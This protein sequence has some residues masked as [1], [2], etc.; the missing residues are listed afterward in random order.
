MAI[1]D[2]IADMLTMIRN[3]VRVKK[4]EVIT[5][6]SGIKRDIAKILK[7][8]GY[9]K[10]F[11]V[12]KEDGL[13]KLKIQLKFLPVKRSA[14]TNIRRVSRPGLRKYAGK[15]KIPKVL[16]GLGTAI[17]STSK[18]LMSDKTARELGV[19]GE[20]IFTVS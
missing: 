17:I 11:S 18:G 16:N 12:V 14:I 13:A 6:L 20:L 3:A 15:D 10:D 7:E 2:P 1:T 5:P 4:P 9:I 8:E 19:G